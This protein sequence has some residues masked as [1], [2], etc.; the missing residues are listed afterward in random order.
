MILKKRSG[1]LQI[2]IFKNAKNFTNFFFLFLL[3]C[4]NKN[5]SIKKNLFV[6]L[7][8]I[9]YIR[10]DCDEYNEDYLYKI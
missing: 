8:K 1:N 2:I 3:G 4:S 5:Y 10:V 6:I 7:H 9:K